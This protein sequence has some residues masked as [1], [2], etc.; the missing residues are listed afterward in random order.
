QRALAV[1]VQERNPASTLHAFRRLL[2][3]R[4]Q[5]PALLWGD[6]EF[7]LAT[8]EVLAFTRHYEGERIL[9][10]FNLSTRAATA[11]LP[12]VLAGTPL[13]GHGLPDGR[14]EGARLA[15]PPHGVLYVRLASG[16]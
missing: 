13:A 6:I 16:G 1:E 2:H 9:A 3:W 8:D 7:L 10:A 12:R 15:I 5:H 14:L 11:E 4:R